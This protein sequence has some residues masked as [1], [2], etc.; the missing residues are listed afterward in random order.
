MNEENPDKP[1]MESNDE[2][3]IDNGSD[4]EYELI[5]K[6]S[7]ID[8]DEVL[9]KTPPNTP[10]PSQE[11]H[12]E[13]QFFPEPRPSSS[14]S[15][16]SI[17]VN[18]G[19]DIEG[20][21]VEILDEFES[22]EDPPIINDELANN[23][24]W[25]F[26]PGAETNDV[27]EPLLK[28]TRKVEF[29]D[30]S[31]IRKLEHH[32]GSGPRHKY[33]RNELLKLNNPNKKARFNC[34]GQH[35]HG[36]DRSHSPFPKLK[37][38]IRKKAPPSRNFNEKRAFWR[39]QEKLPAHKR[40]PKIGSELDLTHRYTI[41][42]PENRSYLRNAL[43]GGLWHHIEDALAKID[44][45]CESLTTNLVKELNNY[46]KNSM[47]KGTIPRQIIGYNLNMFPRYHRASVSAVLLASPGDLLHYFNYPSISYQ[48]NKTVNASEIWN[49][50]PSKNKIV[51]Y[52]MAL[53]AGACLIERQTDRQR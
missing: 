2:L 52:R 20:R 13:N 46:V 1:G 21:E 34:C 49:R 51:V 38:N 31:T 33:Q 42:K 29:A 18:I 47:N 22:L 9:P 32:L 24:E 40:L 41:V 11:R 30:Q 28:R 26:E 17:R 37:K 53:E 15:P 25:D 48:M 7:E 19:S 27:S 35:F 5:E 43:K 12:A 44:D 50:I 4:E 39:R 10:R 3:F 16:S 23:D 6:D 8:V 36:P 45:E 14:S